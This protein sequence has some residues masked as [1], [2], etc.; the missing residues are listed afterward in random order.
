MRKRGFFGRKRRKTHVD[1][2]E[3][4]WTGDRTGGGAPSTTQEEVEDGVID[5]NP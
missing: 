4:G 1:P 5:G 3:D 2:S